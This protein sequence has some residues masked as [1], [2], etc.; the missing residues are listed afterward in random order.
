MHAS[1][2]DSPEGPAAVASHVDAS[3]EQSSPNG[4]RVRRDLI[5]LV[6]DNAINMRV[7]PHLSGCDSHIFCLG[8]FQ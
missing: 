1:L 6:E 2:A 7:S 3:V 5:L 4:D 8:L